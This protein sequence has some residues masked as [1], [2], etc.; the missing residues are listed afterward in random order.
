MQMFDT[1]LLLSER[2]EHGAFGPVLRKHNPSLS[3]ISLTAADEFQYFGTALL[4]RS[5]LVAFATPVVVPAS[6]LLALGYGAFNF[7]PGPPTYP[8]WAPAHFALY[9]GATEF[10]TTLHAM[11]DKVDAGTIVDA[12]FFSV[13]ADTTVAD[14]EKL[15]YS[16]LVRQFLEWAQLLANQAT[17]PTAC[18]P[19]SWS[20]RKGSRRSYQAL[21]NI[22]LDVSKEELERRMRVLGE[23]HFGMM[24]IIT[25]HGFE[26][27]ATQNSVDASLV[28]DPNLDLDPQGGYAFKLAPPDG[29][30]DGDGDAA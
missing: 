27:R 9:E 2:T 19:M 17:P 8:G 6:I 1:I 11:T 22:P 29:N 21:C 5:R 18:R 4:S 20:K 15:A 24:P 14:V 12:R 30:G 7:H 28:G 10:G 16:C 23:S 3:V 13:A 25:L 26:F